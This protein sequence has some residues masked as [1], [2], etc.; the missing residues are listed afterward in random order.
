M[1][2]P[3]TEQNYHE[4]INFDSMEGKQAKFKETQYRSWSDQSSSSIDDIQIE[5]CSVQYPIPLTWFVSNYI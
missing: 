5:I 4:R 1:Q 2:M 3:T